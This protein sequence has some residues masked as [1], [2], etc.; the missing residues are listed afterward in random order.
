ME[1]VLTMANLKLKPFLF[2]P[3]PNGEGTRYMYSSRPKQPASTINIQGWQLTRH[4][5]VQEMSFHDVVKITSCIIAFICN[6]KETL[7]ANHDHDINCLSISVPSFEVP[8][9]I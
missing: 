9:V 8:C 6:Q 3:H 7:P 5:F 2:I 4:W 1:H